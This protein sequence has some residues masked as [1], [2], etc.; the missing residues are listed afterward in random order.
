MAQSADSLV[1]GGDKI[2]LQ[3]PYAVPKQVK[4]SSILRLRPQSTDQLLYLETTKSTHS[5]LTLSG[6]TCGEN[7]A[8]ELTSVA[9]LLRITIHDLLLI[10][11]QKTLALQQGYLR[12]PIDRARLECEPQPGGL[13]P[14][15]VRVKNTNIVYTRSSRSSIGAP[16]SLAFQFG[17]CFELS[18]QIMLLEALSRAVKFA[19]NRHIND[20]I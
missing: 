8:I 16:S 6:T 11:L 4:T 19:I 3:R 14:Q 10:K 9:F 2:F 5:T 1:F 13:L 17:P 12:H 20:N 15:R 18:G 7:I